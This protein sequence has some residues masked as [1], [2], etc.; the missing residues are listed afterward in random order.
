[1]GVPAATDPELILRDMLRPRVWYLAHYDPAPILARITVPVLALNGSLDVQTEPKA[2]LVAWRKRLTHSSDVTVKELPGL[3][4]MFQHART[5]GRG[6]YRD[7][8]ETF[9]PEALALM[10]DWIR[11]RFLKSQSLQ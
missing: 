2:N 5:G 8:E 3:N 1:M 9:A 10:S 7:I 6:E 11:R 4:H